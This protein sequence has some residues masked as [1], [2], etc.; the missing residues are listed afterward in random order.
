MKAHVYV[1]LKRSVLD[2]QG[3][4]VAG[5]LRRMARLG[6]ESGAELGGGI[7]A[8]HNEEIVKRRDRP[9]Q[10]QARQTLIQTMKHIGKTRAKRFGQQST[11]RIRR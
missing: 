5:A 9:A 2:A 6:R 8:R 4:T 11:A 1:T 3:Q 7:L 10:G